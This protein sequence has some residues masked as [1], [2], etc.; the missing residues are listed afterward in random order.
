MN[1]APDTPSLTLPAFTDAISEGHISDNVEF[2]P[3][4]CLHAAPELGAGGT[5]RSPA[6]RVLELDITTREGGQNRGNW[7]ALHLR[8]EGATDLAGD[9]TGGWIGFACRHA[10]PEQQMIR[11]V[12][13]SGTQDGFSDCFFD[14][15]ILATPEARNHLDAINMATNRTIPERAPWR[16]LVLFLPKRALRWHL[17]DLRLFRL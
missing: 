13:R 2:C 12:L 7:M 8:L 1:S 11:P 3:G 5:W 6:G 17:H 16:E 14:K 15:H 4:F 9:L 10:A